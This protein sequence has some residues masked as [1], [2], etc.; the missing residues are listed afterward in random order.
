MASLVGP[1]GQVAD[2]VLTAKS[3]ADQGLIDRRL[4]R[5]G[6][7]PFRSG[8]HLRER[9]RAIVALRGTTAIAEAADELIRGRVAP[10]SPA[11]DGR[12][13]PYRGHPVFVAQHATATCC[14]ACLER[15][16]AIPAGRE[17]TGD[18]RDYVVAV[19]MRW[20]GREVARAP[21]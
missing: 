5:L 21:G 3:L 9:E 19:I 7:V 20:I 17:L 12:Q 15:A 16:H 1:P 13:T 18:E 10:A 4:D 14:R 11:K 2:A 8:F 6:R